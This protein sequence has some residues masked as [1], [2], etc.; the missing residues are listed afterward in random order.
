MVASSGAG[1]TIRLD[2][3]DRECRAKRAQLLAATNLNSERPQRSHD[4]PAVEAAD[5]KPHQLVL[6][7]IAPGQA[8][9]RMR[10]RAV[11]GPGTVNARI[12]RKADI[13]KKLPAA[14]FLPAG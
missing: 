12:N 8:G 2:Q 4:E 6:Q 9:R 14:E 5:E 13:R 7:L 3:T 1:R 10:L 11:V